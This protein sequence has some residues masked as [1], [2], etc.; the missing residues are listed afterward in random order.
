MINIA[1]FQTCW[2][3]HTFKISEN[4]IQMYGRG[5]TQAKHTSYFYLEDHASFVWKIRFFISTTKQVPTLQ[6]LFPFDWQTRQHAPL[7]V[8]ICTGYIV[9]SLIGCDAE[10]GDCH[11]WNIRSF[12]KD[13]LFGWTELCLHFSKRS[14]VKAYYSKQ[15]GKSLDHNILSRINTRCGWNLLHILSCCK[16][17]CSLEVRLACTSVLRSHLVLNS[18]CCRN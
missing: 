15:Q 10:D 16:N 1:K 14:E 9:I 18:N 6:P 11:R 4:K 2:P 13:K 5:I 12:A 7:R 8:T 3:K 17:L